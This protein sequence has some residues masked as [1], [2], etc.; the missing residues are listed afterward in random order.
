MIR[1]N[2]LSN[3]IERVTET[4]KPITADIFLTDLCNNKCKYCRY[5]HSSKENEIIW[6]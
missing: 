5:T 1:G 4:Q 6:I 2:K 3:F